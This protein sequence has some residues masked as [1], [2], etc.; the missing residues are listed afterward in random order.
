MHQPARSEAKPESMKW[1]T[2]ESRHGSKRWVISVVCGVGWKAPSPYPT[3]RPSWVRLTQPFYRSCACMW[4]QLSAIP[5]LPTSLYPLLLS[6]TLPSP[7]PLQYLSCSFLPAPAGETRAFLAPLASAAGSAPAS[8]RASCVLSSSPIHPSTHPPTPAS[9]CLPQWG[10]LASLI[11]RPLL[12]LLL[13]QWSCLLRR[14][15]SASLHLSASCL[16]LS[17]AG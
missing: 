8:L 1:E 13:E 3:Q 15:R 11:P 5:P 2:R 16:A 14:C 7:L 4:Q 9:L 10:S 12:L 6:L 17:F